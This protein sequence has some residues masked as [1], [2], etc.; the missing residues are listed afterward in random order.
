M[1]V[2]KEAL[3]ALFGAVWLRLP[4]KLQR[5]CVTLRS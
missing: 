3:P 4:V 2:V 5:T 1:R